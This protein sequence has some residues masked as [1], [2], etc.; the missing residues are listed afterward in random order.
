MPVLY[1]VVSRWFLV[2]GQGSLDKL[3]E[4][5]CLTTVEQIPEAL[6]VQSTDPFLINRELNRAVLV[7]EKTTRHDTGG[8]ASA[9]LG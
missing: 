2:T 3:A 4:F 6:T 8:V 5:M 1:S 7:E 9:E